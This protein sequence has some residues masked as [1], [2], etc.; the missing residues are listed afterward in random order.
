[1]PYTF[2]R[3]VAYSGKKKRQQLKE[4]NARKLEKANLMDTSSFDYL[5]KN[6][7]E[8]P[9]LSNNFVPAS[10]EPSE[11]SVE[12]HFNTDN[13]GSK[14]LVSVFE[15]LSKQQIE[16]EKLK[17]MQPLNR[18]PKDCLEIK[19]DEFDRYIDFP[20]RPAW[21]YDMTKEE[22][23]KQEQDYFNNW[24]KAT[25]EKYDG[26]ELSWFE[27]NLEVWRQ[28]WRVLEISD[29]LIIIMDI[30]NPLLHFPRS[31]YE[32]ITHILKRPIIGIF[33]KVD[34]VS[35]FTVFCWRKYFEEKYPNLRITTF[36]CYPR[37]PKLINDTAI[38]ALKKQTKRPKKRYYHAQG[39]QDMLS[40][41]KDIV[42]KS[43]VAVDWKSLIDSY[44]ENNMD[45]SEESSDS[46][47]DSMDGL[48][49]E[50]GAIFDI[51]VREVH[52][53]KNYITLGLIGQ[54]NVGKSSLINSI[55][56]KTVVSTSRTPGHTKHFQTIHITDHVR[57]CDSPGLV[58]PAFIPK[59]LQI[60]SGIYP[61]SQVQ[62]PYSSIRY[63]A[64]HIPLEK[65]LSLIP[66]VDLD[67]LEEFQWSAWSICEAFAIQ[68]G[69]HIART[70]DP[71]IYRAANTILRLTTEGRILLS[72]KPPGF[73]SSTKYERLRVKEADMK[74]KEE[75][76]K[77]LKNFNSEDIEYNSGK[78]DLLLIS[79]G[80][81]GALLSDSE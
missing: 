77:E 59:S 75:S 72:F 78:Q 35:E 27:R 30:R 68:R 41:C 45:K 5:A 16:K 52:P 51:T 31:L 65:I 48:D 2:I 79:R 64:E 9:S 34:L 22:I 18:L 36:S 39:V 12:T 49:D 57:L 44:D 33:N 42:H 13:N 80:A 6:N 20:K 8:L 53:H 54:P 4:K 7:K 73:F 29:V 55:M 66:P 58:F 38:Y 69:F 19:V 67:E 10:L 46:D 56:K 15:K 25:E 63:L 32:Y 60:L 61:I 11:N 81:F 43:E 62:E 40:V 1:M 14:R 21:N 47:T 26:K 74:E 3:K 71:D 28:L 24:L 70:A 37:D 50:F 17:S 76:E 23:D